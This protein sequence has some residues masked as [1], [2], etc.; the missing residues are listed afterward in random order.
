MLSG[1]IVEPFS[2]LASEA[3][4]DL[5]GERWKVVFEF[6]IVEVVNQSQLFP[7][8]ANQLPP[9]REHLNF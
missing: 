5:I 6:S 1:I 3:F 9:A 4:D 8:A 2:G 7:V